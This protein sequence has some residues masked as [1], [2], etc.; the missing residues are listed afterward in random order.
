MENKHNPIDTA[1]ELL[2]ELRDEMRQRNGILTRI[3]VGIE[4]H[5]DILT[6]ETLLVQVSK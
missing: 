4:R 3:A 2:Q 6:D 5:N 1:I